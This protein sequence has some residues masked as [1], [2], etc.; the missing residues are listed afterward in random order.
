[1]ILNTSTPWDQLLNTWSSLCLWQCFL[2]ELF[3]A[4]NKVFQNTPRPLS[5]GLILILKLALLKNRL[6]FKCKCNPIFYDEMLYWGQCNCIVMS[7]RHKV[8]YVLYD[9]KEFQPIMCS[10]ANALYSVN[11]INSFKVK[12]LVTLEECSPWVQITTPVDWAHCLSGLSGRYI[13]SY[14]LRKAK[15]LH[16]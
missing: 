7:S 3:N 16:I 14:L 10:L 2:I 13:I 4:S 15:C 9:D 12:D 11:W 1:M 6:Y 5:H 8:Q